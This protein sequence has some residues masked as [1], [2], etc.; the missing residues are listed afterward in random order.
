MRER[1]VLVK[2]RSTLQ[3]VYLAYQIKLARRKFS[4]TASLRIVYWSRDVF[5]IV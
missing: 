2:R 5:N 4:L 3:F 1:P